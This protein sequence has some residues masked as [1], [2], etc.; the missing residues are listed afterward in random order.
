MNEGQK[1]TYFV[2]VKVFLEKDGKLLILKDN[3]G[4]WDLPGGRIKK[5]EFEV[6]LDQIIKRKMSEELGD[7]IKYTIGEPIVFMRHERV[8]Q[9]PG[10][11]VVR[12]FAVGYE[13]KLESGE[14][15]TSKRHPELLWVSLSGFKPEE[16]FKG[17]WL[18][19]VQE[20]LQFRN[21]DGD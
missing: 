12:I 17:G 7:D 5:D 6:P 13:G 1:G 14:V 4:D 16:Y 2:A 15:K 9:A 11:P 8:E 21:E 20:Y 18:K 10:N 19:G 3:F